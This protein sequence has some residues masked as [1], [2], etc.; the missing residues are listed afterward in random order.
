MIAVI[1]ISQGKMTHAKFVQSIVLVVAL[2]VSVSYAVQELPQYQV[3]ITNPPQTVPF[4]TS[5]T[6]TV[7]VTPVAGAGRTV[8]ITDDLGNSCEAL[9]TAG[10]SSST[11]SCSLPQYDQP[12]V[13]VVTAVLEPCQADALPATV[14]VVVLEPTVIFSSISS[15]PSPAGYQQSV[16]INFCLTQAGGFSL[17]AETQAGIVTVT[18]GPQVVSVHPGVNNCGSA[19]IY[20]PDPGSFSVELAY[21]PTTNSYL[22][23]A[24]AVYH[25]SMDLGLSAVISINSTRSIVAKTPLVLQFSFNVTAMKSGREVR[26]HLQVVQGN[27]VGCTIETFNGMGSCAAIFNSLQTE[28]REFDIFVVGDDEVHFV[29]NRRVPLTIAWVPNTFVPTLPYT[30]NFDTSSTNAN[31]LGYWYPDSLTAPGLNGGSYLFQRS[32]PNNTVINAASPAWWTPLT[33]ALGTSSGS[34]ALYSPIFDLTAVGGNVVFGAQLWFELDEGYETAYFDY[35]L[36]GGA[37]T[38]L[39]D[40]NLDIN[41]YTAAAQGGSWGGNTRGYVPVA[42]AVPSAAGAKLQLRLVYTKTLAIIDED[43]VALDNVFL[44][45]TG[46]G[47]PI[48]TPDSA[49]IGTAVALR[50]AS[51]L[52]SPV[53]GGSVTVT[54][55]SG[56]SGSCT[57]AINSGTGSCS[58]TFSSPGVKTLSLAFSA[59]GYDS[60]TTTMSYV[61]TS[62]TTL[63]AASQIFDDFEG[64]T[65][66][67]V[68]WGPGTSSVFAEEFQL[69]SPTKNSIIFDR[70]YSGSNAWITNLNGPMARFRATSYSL[71]SGSFSLAGVTTGSVYFGAAIWHELA[72]TERA[73]FDVSINGAAFSTAPITA[74]Y[75]GMVYN[76]NGYFSDSS[77]YLNN[78]VGWR[79]YWFKLSPAVLNTNFQLRLTVALIAAG[80]P[81]LSDGVAFD[82]F[83]LTAGLDPVVIQHTVPRQALAGKPVTVTLTA[84]DAFNGTLVAGGSFAISVDTTATGSSA[85]SLSA[86]SCTGVAVNG[87]TAVATC[88]L[89]FSSSSNAFLTL[90]ISYTPLAGFSSA[91]TSVVVDVRTDTVVLT[92]QANLVFHENFDG[93]TTNSTWIV[94]G[95]PVWSLG[96]PAGQSITTANSYPNSFSTVT[97]GSLP[98]QPP[99]FFASTVVS[100]IFDLSSWD[101][102]APLYFAFYV[103]SSIVYSGPWV[104][105]SVAGAEFVPIQDGAFGGNNDGLSTFWTNDNYLSVNFFDSIPSYVQA[106]HSLPTGSTVQFRIRNYP[107]YTVP[108]EAAFDDV[109]LFS[110]QVDPTVVGQFGLLDT[111]QFTFSFAAPSLFA[112]QQALVL[113]LAGDTSG[114]V[115]IMQGAVFLTGGFYDGTT[116]LTLT[117]RFQAVNAAPIT[118]TYSPTSAYLQTITARVLPLATAFP[119]VTAF[120]YTDGFEGS[121]VWTPLAVDGQLPTPS[122]IWTLGSGPLGVSTGSFSW[123]TKNNASN[124]AQENLSTYTL[125]SPVL[126]LTKFPMGTTVYYITAMVKAVLPLDTTFYLS[127]RHSNDGQ[128]WS[129]DFSD[130]AIGYL[131]TFSTFELA[132]PIQA[133]AHYGQFGLSFTPSNVGTAAVA[134]DNIYAG[135]L[136]VATVKIASPSVP[137]TTVGVNTTVSFQVAAFGVPVLGIF[138]ATATGSSQSCFYNTTLS[139]QNLNCYF[140]FTTAGQQLIT[141]QVQPNATSAVLPSSFS[142]VFDVLPVVQVQSLP[143]TDTFDSTTQWLTL[144]PSWHLGAPSGPVITGAVSGNSAWFIQGP[145]GLTVQNVVSSPDNLLLS[146]VFDLTSV[147]NATTTLWF[148]AQAWVRHAAATISLSGNPGT[149][150][151]VINDYDTHGYQQYWF[152]VPST[153]ISTARKFSVAL[154]VPG[155]LAFGEGLA[156]DNFQITNLTP[157]YINILPPTPNDVQTG[158]ITTISFQ[159][160]PFAG[161]TGIAI[162]G[163]VKVTAPTDS[164]IA[165]LDA[166]GRGR[167]AL[168]LVVPASLV[169]PTIVSLAYTPTN[170][171]VMPSTALLPVRVHYTVSLTSATL[172]YFDNFENPQG[173]NLIAPWIAEDAI[174]QNGSPA[175]GAK[176][177]LTSPAS[178]THA[179]FTRLDGGAPSGSNSAVY[180]PVF[181]IT[182]LPETTPVF[183][184]FKFMAYTGSSNDLTMVQTRIDD[185]QDWNSIGNA[186]DYLNWYNINNGPTSQG[187]GGLTPYQ[188]RYQPA[189]HLVPR[190]A[191]HFVQ[192][193]FLYQ[194]SGMSPEFDGFALDD[195]LLAAGFPVSIS[196][197]S[198]VPSPMPA[199]ATGT[200]SFQVKVPNTLVTNYYPLGGSVTVVLDSGEQCSTSIVASS[201][202]PTTAYGQCSLPFNSPGTRIINLEF[203]GPLYYNLTTVSYNTTTVVRAQPAITVLSIGNDNTPVIAGLVSQVTVSVRSNFFPRVPTG[204]VL[205]S[206]ASGSSCNATLRTD[207]TASCSLL[208]PT[209]GNRQLGVVYYGDDLH[210][211]A[212]AYVTHTVLA[213]VTLTNTNLPVADTFDGAASTWV[214]D[215]WRPQTSVEWALGT[216]NGTFITS[217]ASGANAWFTPL[218][219]TPTNTPQYVYSPVFNVSQIIYGTDIIFSANIFW[220]MGPN[221][222]AVLQYRTDN[223]AAPNDWAPL[224]KLFEPTNWFN[225][226]N[227]WSGTD[228]RTYRQAFHQ[229]ISPKGEKLVQLRF[230]LVHSDHYRREDGFAF[231][232]ATVRLT[233]PATITF[234]PTVFPIQFGT[235]ANVTVRAQSAFY[236]QLAGTYAVTLGDGQTCSGP[237]DASGQIVC[238]FTFLQQSSAT[239]SATFTSASLPTASVSGSSTLPLS[240]ILVLT[241][242]TVLPQPYLNTFETPNAADS[243]YT[244]S[245]NFW[246]LTTNPTLF[247]GAASGNNA[248]VFT[249]SNEDRGRAVSPGGSTAQVQQFSLYSPV[250][251]ASLI[252]GT[253]NPNNVIWVSMHLNYDLDV[254]DTLFIDSYQSNV[255]GGQAKWHIVSVRSPVLNNFYSGTTGFSSSTNGIYVNVNFQVTLPP[256]KLLHLRLRVTSSTTTAYSRGVAVDDFLIS[257]YSPITTVINVPSLVTL[258]APATFSA[259]IFNQIPGGP[260]NLNATATFYE[261]QSTTPLCVV[262]KYTPCNITLTG[263]PRMTSLR[264]LVQENDKQPVVSNYPTFSI[265]FPVVQSVA[266]GG[267]YYDDFESASNP[268]WVPGDSDFWQKGNPKG[269]VIHGTSSGVNA[270]FTNRHT[271]IESSVGTTLYSPVFDFTAN[272]ATSVTIGLRAWWDVVCSGG[273]TI[274]IYTSSSPYANTKVPSAQLALNA[275]A[276]LNWYTS[277]CSGQPGWSN[278]L[279]GSGA[280]VPAYAEVSASQFTGNRVQ[281]AVVLTTQNPLTEQDGFAFDDF[282]I[283]QFV[284]LPTSLHVD[285]IFPNQP[286]VGQPATFWWSVHELFGF[287][288]SFG[289]TVVITSSVANDGIVCQ[290]AVNLYSGVG[291]CSGTFSSAGTRTLTLTYTPSD[292]RHQASSTT[293]AITV[294][295]GEPTI[296]FTSVVPEPS[297][298]GGTVTINLLVRPVLN[299]NTSGRA[300]QGIVTVSDS[301]GGASCTGTLV[302]GATSCTLTFNSAGVRTLTASYTPTGSSSIASTATY[303]HEVR[304]TGTTVTGIFPSPVKIGVP[305]TVSFQLSTAPSTVPYQGAVIVSI[306]SES[307][308]CT[309]LVFG[310]SGTCV[311]PALSVAGTQTITATFY[312]SGA[313]A[314]PSSGSRTLQVDPVLTTYMSFSLGPN[315]IVIPN[316]GGASATVSVNDGSQP[317]GGVLFTLDGVSLCNSAFSSFAPGQGSA[318]CAIPAQFVL[319]NHLVTATYPLVGI[320]SPGS[321]ANGTYTVIGATTTLT[322]SSSPNPSYVA[323]LTTTVT[324]TISTNSGQPLPGF[325]RVTDSVS[326][327]RCAATFDQINGGAFACS[328]KVTAPGAHNITVR[329]D[330]DLYNPATSVSFIQTVLVNPPGAGG[331]PNPTPTPIPFRDLEN[332]PS[333][334]QALLLRGAALGHVVRA[335]NSS[336]HTKRSYVENNQFR[337]IVAQALQMSVSHIG[338]DDAAS[339]SF[340]FVLANDNGRSGAVLIRELI[341]LVQ[342]ND[343]DI[344]GTILEGA[345]ITLTAPSPTPVPSPPPIHSPS[346]IPF[347]TPAPVPPSKVP[348]YY[349]G[350]PET[351]NTAASVSSS[352]LLLVIS[353]LVMLFL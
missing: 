59:S 101:S 206:D 133:G 110:G 284:T 154:D 296:I 149:A 81:R 310:N 208:F 297:F 151:Y 169:G 42:K 263:S 247:F 109:Y 248:W 89:T 32:P 8:L 93:P 189:A 199:G 291:S 186:A 226:Q 9:L 12:G 326:N 155:D 142:F 290:R 163:T 255:A 82:N 92:E 57:A 231:D 193:R 148:G 256:N 242:S 10:A 285:D 322:A 39:E 43:G 301:Q 329:Y 50:V 63:A 267:A 29:G 299:P 171:L 293:V 85:A 210:A 219:L 191:R 319:G 132:I 175:P 266:V 182:S 348:Y 159:V 337:L 100:P 181:D 341:I 214:T 14:N 346:Y 225:R 192:F 336:S 107:L 172:P 294:L 286:V 15:I 37:W 134:L 20:I 31:G 79:Q 216:P 209:A 90:S 64:T 351:V 94:T 213:V 127:Y 270:W 129:L 137:S 115:T 135:V 350:K 253:T 241:N 236:N 35:S 264:V 183:V 187:Y 331:P 146:P 124:L 130:Q 254:G 34:F 47:L 287:S 164:C 11:G 228:L 125:A 220:N 344:R 36:N 279:S 145:S 185:D 117:F 234:A 113:P 122:N 91:R 5:I 204:T 41:W 66:G 141:V 272:N 318:S 74:V 161:V 347:Q 86:N 7:A 97:N 338:V 212:S 75:N 46:V 56:D 77:T 238:S 173:T 227:G 265:R 313:Q 88:S 123:Y 302:T 321:S 22:P 260:T 83:Q 278:T 268:T 33:S 262:N 274:F 211:T 315:P 273:A 49:P 243:W 330:G 232:D 298:V 303:Q 280:Y 174:W 221:N 62:A 6:I 160:V 17:P 207:T 257:P 95:H 239:I 1:T 116:P 324:G 18:Y 312:P 38:R 323:N 314:P 112:G 45:T 28:F 259:S 98:Y 144:S 190:A 30:E 108:Y 188:V 111:Y 342:V 104:E 306:G 218:Q 252:A 317:L 4:G 167:C 147:A 244:D 138:T 333:V 353:A 40:T 305:V 258:N 223:Q 87:S 281:L 131:P 271:R 80:D 292:G 157:T 229:L 69:G 52:S 48:L 277:A 119:V 224:G 150:N 120:P 349:Y 198:V 166:N 21:L 55:T 222:F 13:R 179:W 334:A 340:D 19:I 300:P 139:A 67:L 328:I 58:I 103:A 165:T 233:A 121:N 84:I 275:S 153:A 269:V 261:G 176:A 308:T 251:N 197:L 68:S 25:Q 343:P 205:I 51:P 240:N 99:N 126:D 16:Q 202:S 200:V 201:L 339:Q 2:L 53:S 105:A 230:V 162:T 235:R 217:A 288:R 168:T 195:F 70:A 203:C 184:A 106:L 332:G 196:L 246:Q 245:P 316:G 325:L 335:S 237:S 215:V 180:S 194:S 250:I 73:F 304:Q 61:V 71:V 345:T 178:G 23:P 352:C 76:T 72:V 152:Q 26:G 177:Y 60:S 327:E 295:P 143:Y 96:T 309:T 320:N 114:T 156:L 128:T 44:Q 307:V 65:P 140:V 78:G 136:P 27:N 54:V 3:T 102:T 282:A 289:G 24:Y 170:P 158:Q 276:E 311:L 283:G 249:T 118:Y